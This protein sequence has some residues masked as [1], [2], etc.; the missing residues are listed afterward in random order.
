[1]KTRI[2]IM[3]LSIFFFLPA[4]A[5]QEEPVNKK[6]GTRTENLQV[7]YTP[8]EEPATL[9]NFAAGGGGY[10]AYFYFGDP[11]GMYLDPQWS[12]GLVAVKDGEGMEAL[13]RYN[14]YHQKVEAITEADTFAFA[15]PGELD[16]VMIGDRK[17]IFSS[18]LRNDLEVANTWFEVLC[19]GEC[20]LLLRH[21]IKYRLA[22]GDDDPTNDQMY[23]MEAYYSRKKDE[24][25]MRLSP[26]RKDIP[27][28]LLDHQE[29]LAA[30][31]K[32]NKLNLKDQDDLVKLFTYYNSLDQ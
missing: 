16:W 30:Y 25:G 12:P 9:D 27:L 3:V 20:D 15:K 21:Y 24:S 13:L 26:T 8:L 23:K 32:E 1:M 18:Y 6:K 22:D 19:E 2:A 28:V 31:L 14:I 29:E 5:Q 11:G 4:Y 7:N 10:P 17:F